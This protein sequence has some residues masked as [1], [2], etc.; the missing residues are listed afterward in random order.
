MCKWVAE[1]MGHSYYYYCE[2]NDEGGQTDSYGGEIDAQCDCTGIPTDL[3]PV[4][5]MGCHLTEISPPPPSPAPGSPPPHPP[6]YAHDWVIDNTNPNGEFWYS[7]PHKDDRD[8]LQTHPW[9]HFHGT[10]SV[11]AR[12]HW[13]RDVGT[14]HDGTAGAFLKTHYNTG[15]SLLSFDASACGEVSSAHIIGNVSFWWKYHQTLNLTEYTHD[16]RYNK[17]P[18]KVAMQIT[19][20]HPTNDPWN[21]GTHNHPDTARTGPHLY[22]EVVGEDLQRKTERAEDSGDRGW[23]HESVAIHTLE[24]LYFVFTWEY[25]DMHHAHRAG[26]ANDWSWMPLADKPVMYVD[27]LHVSCVVAPPSLP[28]YLPSPPPS[29]PPTPPPTP[30]P[31]T[32]PPPTP[33]PPTPPP[34]TPPPP[35]PPPPSP[36]PLPPPPS[37]PPPSPPPS[38]PP[39]SPPPPSPPPPSPP[40]PSPLSPWHQTDLYFHLEHFDPDFTNTRNDH[41]V[42]VL[43]HRHVD[44]CE[45]CI[46]PG[47]ETGANNVSEYIFQHRENSFVEFQVPHLSSAITIAMHVKVTS[48]CD[49]TADDTFSGCNLLSFTEMVSAPYEHLGCFTDRFSSHDFDPVEG[50][51]WKTVTSLDKCREY[52]DGN[53]HFFAMQDTQCG[54]T[55]V[56]GRYGQL[57]DSNC[58][59]AGA[60]GCGVGGNTCGGYSRNSLYQLPLSTPGF[61]LLANGTKFAI[62]S[63]QIPQFQ[64][65]RDGVLQ[66]DYSSG[67]YR[68]YH[69]TIEKYTNDAWHRIVLSKNAAAANWLLSFKE[70]T[71]TIPLV[72][73]DAPLNYRLPRPSKL[74]IGGN[75]GGS[76]H[77]V[78]IHSTELHDQ[79]DQR[80]SLPPTVGVPPRPFSP[81]TPPLLP[82]PP[83]PPSPPAPPRPPPAFPPGCLH[84]FSYVLI[85]Q[86]SD[87]WCDH[88]MYRNGLHP[89]DSPDDITAVVTAWVSKFEHSQT[90]A[91]GG[92]LMLYNGDAQWAS[93]FPQTSQST[94]FSNFNGWIEDHPITAQPGGSNLESAVDKIYEKFQYDDNSHQVVYMIWAD[95]AGVGTLNSQ[96]DTKMST[97]NEDYHVYI[98]SLSAMHHS[99]TFNKWVDG[100]AYGAEC[101]QHPCNNGYNQ[102]AV[103]T[104]TKH[105]HQ[106]CTDCRPADSFTHCDGTPT[107]QT[108]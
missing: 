85:L 65:D 87:G 54:C 43:T 71:L 53:S 20:E 72:H 36:P 38:P 19:E 90:H 12:R 49:G 29:R 83:S 95:H 51:S 41:N 13:V 96:L 66:H 105:A 14:R 9:D 26:Q 56:Y 68:A 42:S 91:R 80:P 98:L 17:I 99:A 58:N 75:F 104:V 27:E 2:E 24:D 74:R 45:G 37:P 25:E 78:V 23:T 73:G 21:W 47:Y 89:A 5:K 18:D 81:P 10:P 94:I 32:P 3:C 86:W 64:A 77:S 108:G 31:P 92:I 6:G 44:A 69:E 62:A 59:F 40:P 102:F 93:E 28:P 34:P 8:P 39:P 60:S 70:E 97:L 57:A 35:T 88:C 50:F 79:Y 7:F 101:T 46:A 16:P 30:P 52:C 61:A 4:G 76:M 11:T 100:G 63:N 1:F 82:P 103:D 67:D 106:E 55:N 33:T 48:D 84:D 22:W 107:Y 15:Y